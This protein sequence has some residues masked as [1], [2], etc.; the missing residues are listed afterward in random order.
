MEAS[1][2]T[3]QDT[4]RNLIYALLSFASPLLAFLIILGYQSVAHAQDWQTLEPADG[5][6]GAVLG[7]AEIIQIAIAV[8][9][10]TLVGLVFALLCVRRRPIIGTIALIF[11]GLPLVALSFLVIRGMTRG[12]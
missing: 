4:R 12:W 11:N 8:L 6:A 5:M 3:H 7:L 2:F 10:G 1:R 9:V